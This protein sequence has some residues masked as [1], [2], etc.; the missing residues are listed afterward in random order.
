M[1][2]QAEAPGGAQWSFDS[3][4]G[5]SGWEKVDCKIKTGGEQNMVF[6]QGDP[7]PF[8][9]PSAYEKDTLQEVGYGRK[10][11][12]TKMVTV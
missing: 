2:K 5:V 11:T 6:E 12:K 4:E 9:N 8:Y 7:P 1:W 10:Q 3:K